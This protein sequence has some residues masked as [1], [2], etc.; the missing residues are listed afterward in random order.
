MLSISAD[1]V[2][3]ALEVKGSAVAV[4]DVVTKVEDIALPE[5][6]VVEVPSG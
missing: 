4:E 6:E 5:F 3:G 1:G 2:F